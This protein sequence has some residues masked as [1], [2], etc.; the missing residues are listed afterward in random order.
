MMLNLFEMQQQLKDMKS[1]RFMEDT[2]RNVTIVCYMVDDPELWKHPL[3]LECRG[4]V[5]DTKTG[6]CLCRPFEKFFNFHEL[7]SDKK[8]SVISRIDR[9]S[10]RQF[11]KK[12]DGSMITPVLLPSGEL[13]FKTKKSFDSDVAKLAKKY[14]SSNISEDFQEWCVN[15]CEN[16]YTPI[17]EFTSLDSEIVI[18]YG[19]EPTLTLL[20]VRSIHSG[21]YLELGT[22]THCIP[23]IACDRFDF[24]EEL[25]EAQV[26]CEGEEGW[27]LEI[28]DTSD[29]SS[30]HVKFKTQWY[31]DRH[32]LLDLRERDVADAVI[33]DKIDDLRESMVAA[34]ADLMRLY[35]IQ[36]RVVTELTDLMGISN[37]LLDEAKSRDNTQKGVA[38]FVIEH[39]KEFVP[40]VMALFAGDQ[41]KAERNNKKLWERTFREGYKLRSIVNSKFGEE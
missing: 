5:F 23:T 39:G 3:G 13:D 40:V 14:I 35:E 15:L 25:E 7:D 26:N 4:A 31:N 1:V 2:A 38:L 18:R 22:L 32:R 27:V 36:Q 28:I 30:S 19:D 12:R 8:K 17:F 33:E 41:S 29:F 20:A 16:G 24:Y 34:G 10:M 11:T 21:K 6:E 9:G 37:K